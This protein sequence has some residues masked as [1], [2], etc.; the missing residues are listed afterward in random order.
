MVAHTRLMSTK[1]E[2]DITVGCRITVSATPHSFTPK[3]WAAKLQG[4]FN[5][6]QL[7][8]GVRNQYASTGTQ[9]NGYWQ[10]VDAIIDMLC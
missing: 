3:L 10:R 4:Q 9:Y 6:K 5:N 8:I 7:K 1:S 2:T